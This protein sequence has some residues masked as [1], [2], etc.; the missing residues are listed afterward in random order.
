MG[1][2]SSAWGVGSWRLLAV[3][4]IALAGASSGCGE[5][6]VTTGGGISPLGGFRPARD[7]GNGSVGYLATIDTVPSSKAVQYTQPWSRASPWEFPW[8]DA[9]VVRPLPSLSMRWIF[10]LVPTSEK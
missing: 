4:G 8:P 6:E 9:S 3:V 2:A 5:D 1:S 7:D 10:P